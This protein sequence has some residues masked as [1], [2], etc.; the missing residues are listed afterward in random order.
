MTHLSPA[1]RRKP[2][3]TRASYVSLFQLLT[4]DAWY[5]ENGAGEQVL[6]VEVTDAL[7]HFEF[8]L[9]T[10]LNSIAFHQHVNQQA[11]NE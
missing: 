1:Q 7:E 10:L 3:A 6:V 8:L 2:P 4:Q 5:A 11:D 9:T